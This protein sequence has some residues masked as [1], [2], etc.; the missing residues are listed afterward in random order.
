MKISEIAKSKGLS[1][2][3]WGVAFPG[4]SA[5]LPIYENGAS[6]LAWEEVKALCE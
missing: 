5:A 2:M 4:A 3:G 6:D 1:F